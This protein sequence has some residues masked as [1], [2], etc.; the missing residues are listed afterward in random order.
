MVIALLIVIFFIPS[1]TKDPKRL[2]ATFD[3]SQEGT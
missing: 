3:K 1:Q 2:A